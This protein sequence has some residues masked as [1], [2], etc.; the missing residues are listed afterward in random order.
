MVKA[1]RNDWGQLEPFLIFQNPPIDIEC[2]CKSGGCGGGSKSKPRP[3]PK[4]KTYKPVT[5]KPK[6]WGR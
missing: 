6:T 3:T 5:I 2:G 4:P 1:Y